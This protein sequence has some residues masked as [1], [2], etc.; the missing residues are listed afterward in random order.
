MSAEFNKSLRRIAKPA[1]ESVGFNFDGKRR[2]TKIGYDERELV[3][4]YQVG[5]GTMQGE[6][7]VNLIVGESMER[8]GMIKSTLLSKAVN[9]LFGDYDPW[10]KGVFLPKDKWWKISP[11]QEE[12][13]SIVGK[14][15]AELKEYGIA[16]IE[17]REET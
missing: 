12:M 2:F 7:T 9:K 8:L 6:F 15:V 4:E 11:F 1:L 10:W 3:I 5:I 17:R 13:D 16:W 14:T